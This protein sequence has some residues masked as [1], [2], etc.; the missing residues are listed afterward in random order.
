LPSV[1]RNASGGRLR[2]GAPVISPHEVMPSSMTHPMLPVPKMQ[3]P[4]VSVAD[5]TPAKVTE[6]AAAGND[7]LPVGAPKLVNPF[8]YAQSLKAR[9]AADLA[10]ATQA[11]QEHS[12]RKY[13]NSEAIRRALA[14]LRAA[15]AARTQR[16]QARYPHASAGDEKR[17]ARYSA[18]GGCEGGGR[19]SNG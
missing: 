4:P 10:S 16:K 3:P 11:L 2:S 8:E 6:I 7:P 1:P 13:P 17:R 14:E 15:E 19:G 12:Q 9:A 18:D 5:A